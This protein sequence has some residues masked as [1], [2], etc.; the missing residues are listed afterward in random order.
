MV[1]MES[2]RYFCIVD[3]RMMPLSLSRTRS[4]S[5]RICRRISYSSGLAW[6]LI[7]SSE[8]MALK[9]SS[10]SARL[11]DRREPSSVR[12]GVSFRSVT[13]AARTTRA[14]FSASATARRALGERVAPTRARLS[15][16][17]TSVNHAMGLE[18]L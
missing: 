13:S 12:S 5:T 1:M 15:A 18:P 6:S 16:S 17:R 3:E 9:M 11:A 7:S 14:A 10:S 8:R 4:F 2:I